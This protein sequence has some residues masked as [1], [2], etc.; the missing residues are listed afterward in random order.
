[1]VAME[2]TMTLVCECTLLVEA[3]LGGE[4]GLWVDAGVIKQTFA[5]AAIEYAWCGIAVFPCRPEDK[6]PYTGHG[7]KDATTRKH[8]I[9][10]WWKEW[11]KALIGIPQ[12]SVTGQLTVDLE[13]PDKP[14]IDVDGITTWNKLEA[15]HGAAP[16]TLTIATPS[17]GRHLRFKHVDGI[18][19]IGLGRIGP[20]I[21]I[22]AEGGYVIASPSRLADGRCYEQVGDCTKVADAPPWLIDL[23]KKASEREGAERF[24][25]DNPPPPE[26]PVKLQAALARN[27]E[28]GDDIADELILPTVMT[29]EQMHD[30]LVYVGEIGTIADRA[31]GRVRKKEHASNEY[32]ASKHAIKKN[33]KVPALG[34]WM[35][36]PRRVTVD[37]LTWF[38]GRPQICR[39]PEE[40]GTAFN[41]WRGL[42]PMEAPPADWKQRAEPFLEHVAFLV[43]VESERKRFLQWLAHIFQHPEVLPHTMY[44]MT[45]RTTGI[46][47][48][49]LASILVRALRGHVAVGVSLPELL[50]GGY[51][52]RLSKKLLV[53]IDEA[54]EGSGERRYQRAERLKSILTEDH[55]HINPK[56][57]FQSIQK[58]CCRW[59][60]FSNH[61]DAIPFDNSDRRVIVIANPTVPKEPAYYER[62]YGM[63]ED[64]AF[65]ASVRRWLETHDVSGFRV[66]EHAPTNTAKQVALDAMLTEVEHLV[67]EF[68]EECMTDLTSRTWVRNH[69]GTHGELITENQLT[70]AIR[71]AG[72]VATARRIELGDRRHRVLIVRGAWTV[73]AVKNTSDQALIKV[74]TKDAE[75][76]TV[77]D[78]TTGK[79]VMKKKT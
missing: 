19:S 39:A 64:G 8:M 79:N 29:L 58:N 61:D 10:L 45:T 42:T 32:A 78:V 23:L 41:T 63:L 16:D 46:G 50:D 65:I 25:P 75:N 68:K 57:G 31:S 20:G 67:I 28:I 15:E 66:G 13:G 12:G 76:Q 1:M 11:P 38:P 18:R 6:A 21:E 35:E 2:E 40:E 59:L 77:V 30:N 49:L 33:K 71:R 62:L 47:R 53:T 27:I 7:Y 36:S 22:K 43:P 9:Q 69:L 14:G 26:P 37:V 48:N 3:V 70:Y 60:L 24:D 73:E 17:R 54:R 72:M 4:G 51:T 56:F 52:G 44:L 34:L 55:R 5:A 74:M